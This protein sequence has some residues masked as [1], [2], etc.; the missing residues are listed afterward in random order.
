[1]PVL[2]YKTGGEIKKKKDDQVVFHGSQGRVELVA[3][4][5]DEAR[6]SEPAHP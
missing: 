3:S 1:M 4:N 6:A 5:L 2:R